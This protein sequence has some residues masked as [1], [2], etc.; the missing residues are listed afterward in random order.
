[1]KKEITLEQVQALI[2]EECD[3]IKNL[4][5]EKNKSYGNS[6]VDPKRIFSRVSP[7]EQIRVRIDDKLSRLSNVNATDAE[8]SKAEDTEQDLIGYL[9][10]LRVAKRVHEE[11]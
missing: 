8:Y 6:A 7:V 2:A 4:L 10:L 1:M 11:K 9:I 5:L 3:G